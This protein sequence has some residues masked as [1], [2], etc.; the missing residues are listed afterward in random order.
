MYLCVSVCLC[1]SVHVCLCVSV[2]VS[3]CV[4]APHKASLGIYLDRSRSFCGELLEALIFLCPVV[5]QAEWASHRTW[6]SI[7]SVVS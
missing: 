7:L 1:V 5:L 2:Y 3:A 6:A 4:Y